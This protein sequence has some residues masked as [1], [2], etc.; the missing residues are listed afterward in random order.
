MLCFNSPMPDVANPTP[1]PAPKRAMPPRIRRVLGVVRTL[2]AYGQNLAETLEQHASQPR[3]LLCFRF[4]A[5]IFASRDI[6]QILARIKR[7]L[8]RAAALEDRLRN[9]AATGRDIRP[10]RT[11]PRSERK[12]GTAGST[13]PPAFDSRF[14]SIE[15]IANQV[16]RRSIGTVL[17]DICLDLG[18]IP[19]QMDPASWNELGDALAR[20]GGDLSNL[21][22]W[23][24]PRPL[25][26][27]RPRNP[28]FC[29]VEIP[30]QTGMF[31]PTWPEPPPLPSPPLASTGPP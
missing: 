4:I 22:V 8:L 27:N 26:R 5:T 9:R 14:P 7:G 6:A 13:R 29:P 24:Q 16:K 11:R 25:P 18:I 12:P 2:I 3:E 28:S 20:Y 17:V 21:V 19:G 30:G 31:F 23:R 10:L 15:Q 1:Q